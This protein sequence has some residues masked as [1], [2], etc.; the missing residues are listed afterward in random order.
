MASAEPPERPSFIRGWRAE[1]PKI[2]ASLTT[3]LILFLASLAFAPVRQW[4]VPSKDRDY[5]LFCTAEQVADLAGK[6]MLV[7]FYI[8]NRTDETLTDAKLGARLAEIDQRTGA[9]STAAI[10]LKLWRDDGQIVGAG[11]DRDFNGDKGDLAILPIARGVAVTVRRIEPRAI[12]R[13]TI[14][15]AG[16]PDLQAEPLSARG[17]IPLNI[18]DYA[19]ACYGSA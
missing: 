8:V 11:P 7:R 6:R 19:E 2:A 18:G 1:W 5:P 12:L 3:A 13:V 10:T 4:L 15:I 9:R 14:P 17:V 16:L